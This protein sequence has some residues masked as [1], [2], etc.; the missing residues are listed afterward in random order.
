[1]AVSQSTK[2][3]DPKKKPLPPLGDILHQVLDVDKDSKVKMAEVIKQLNF[4]EKLFKS[5]DT[6]DEENEYLT[7]VGNAKLVSGDLF[8]LMDANNDYRLTKKELKFATQ[9]ERSLKDGSMKQFVRESFEIIDTNRDDQLSAEEL[10]KALPKTGG[11]INDSDAVP[12]IAAK[13]HAMFPQLRESPQQLE[14]F[15]R[16]TIGDLFGAGDAIQW[17]DDNGDGVIQRVEVGQA[18]NKAGKKF[19]EISNQ[20]KQYGPM[21]SLF[22][23]DENKMKT[24]F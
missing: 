21:L 18:Y 9:F 6:P 17:L 15:I 4:L 14:V 12:Q 24:E 7:M 19:I 3:K 8:K 23:V 2:T 1:V 13:F 16:T 10:D 20:I 22:S 5:T 11:N